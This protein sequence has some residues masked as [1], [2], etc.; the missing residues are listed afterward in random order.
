MELFEDENGLYWE[1]K[2]EIASD[3]S[4]IGGLQIR[5]VQHVEENGQTFKIV[6]P[7]DPTIL[8]VSAPNKWRLSLL[9]VLQDG[10]KAWSV[11]K[12]QRVESAGD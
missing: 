10:T 11:L 1:T 3:P 8:D 12:W 2:V 7:V 5:R 6:R 4:R 9:T